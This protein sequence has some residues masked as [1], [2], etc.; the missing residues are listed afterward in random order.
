MVIEHMTLATGRGFN[1]HG[2][3]VMS[4]F[5]VRV[6]HTVDHS[7]DKHDKPTA[8]ENN[9]TPDPLE[10]HL[11]LSLYHMWSLRNFNCPP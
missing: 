3:Q 10:K 8:T 2:G 5:C 4:T 6:G 9:V 1:G 7:W 11:M